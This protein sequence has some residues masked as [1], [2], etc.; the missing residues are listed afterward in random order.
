MVKCTK[1]GGPY[2]ECPYHPPISPQPPSSAYPC[3]CT[4]T[5]NLICHDMEARMH[6]DFQSITFQCSVIF[7]ALENYEYTPQWVML[8]LHSSF[9]Q[10]MLR[11]SCWIIFPR[12]LT[13]KE[14]WFYE[15]ESDRCLSYWEIFETFWKFLKNFSSCQMKAFYSHGLILTIQNCLNIFCFETKKSSWQKQNQKF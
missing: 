13:C 2:W 9:Y 6:I 5:K 4:V 15:I 11:I 12:L 7:L 14:D 10:N 1:L 8:F 3:N